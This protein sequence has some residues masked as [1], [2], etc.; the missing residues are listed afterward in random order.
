M[1]SRHSL[2]SVLSIAAFVFS[3]VSS[4]ECPSASAA[5][6]KRPNIVLIMTDDM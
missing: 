2:S 4:L 6:A 5:S 3:V 1:P